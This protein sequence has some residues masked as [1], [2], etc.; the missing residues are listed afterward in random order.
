MLI[1]D[2]G[3]AMAA[4]DSR[5]TIHRHV[6]PLMSRP[7]RASFACRKLLNDAASHHLQLGQYAASLI[8][9]QITRDL[10]PSRSDV[11]GLSAAI[12]FISTYRVV[13]P[14]RVSIDLEL[15]G[16]A[17]SYHYRPNIS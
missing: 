14:L 15:R 7:R 10:R 3:L 5:V 17:P 8:T 1:L 16:V 6:G 13:R 12:V 9:V 2:A 11:S 4:E